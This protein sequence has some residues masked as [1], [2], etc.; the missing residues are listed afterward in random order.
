LVAVAEYLYLPSWPD[1]LGAGVDQLG[2]AAFWLAALQIVFINIML[3]GDNA[4]V[5]AMACRGLPQP[6]R[7]WGLIIGA[8][9]AVILLVVFTGVIARLLLLPYVKLIGG[10][11]LLFIAAKLLVPEPPDK[12][13]G[14]AIAHL[15]RAIRLIIVADVIMSLD[16]IIAI[17][18]IAKGDVLLLAIGLGVSIPI[19][20]AGAALIMALLARLPILV[21]LGAALLGL[22]AGETMASDSIVTTHLI[23]DFGEK[24]A[25]HI[26]FALAIT[27]AMLAVAAGGLWRSLQFARRREASAPAA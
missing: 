3:S 4:V 14:E 10:A 5:I 24:T 2:H 15:W 27:A 8:V 1:W 9:I 22:V 19:I 11:V 20:L 13:A 12:S 6:Q 21:W 25:E 7:R 16:N 17:A 26:E 18:A 23:A